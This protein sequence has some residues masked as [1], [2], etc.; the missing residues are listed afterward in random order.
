MKRK[1]VLYDFYKKCYYIKIH[2]RELKLVDNQEQYYVSGVNGLY[3]EISIVKMEDG[4][5]YYTTRKILWE[6]YLV[7]LKREEV[8]LCN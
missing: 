2:F 3:N 6:E 7:G 5:I 4:Y 8:L 1:K